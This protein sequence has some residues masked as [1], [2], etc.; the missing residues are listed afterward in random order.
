[1]RN[2]LAGALFALLASAPPAVAELL[3][4]QAIYDLSMSRRGGDM[5]GGSGRI[6]YELR[7]N[8][9]EG[10]TT[11]VRQVTTLAGADG[12]E[13]TLDVTATTFE[14]G[15]A[16]ALDFR[17][18]TRVDGRLVRTVEGRA[19][20]EEDQLRIALRSPQTREIV[21]TPEETLFPAE[22]LR[23]I[24]DAV[25]AGSRIFATP[26]FDGGDAG[27]EVYD[28]L[29][30]IGGEVGEGTPDPAFPEIADDRRWRATISYFDRAPVEGER[31]PVYVVS[32][33]L[34]ENGVTSDMELDFGDF[35]MRGV[36]TSFESFAHTDARADCPPR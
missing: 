20:R 34:H 32:F 31:T 14:T 17:S 30:V 29:A 4:H 8:A 2:V 3:A 18:Q 7:G 1:M 15:E 6:V 36:M 33:A 27:D 24:L 22:H 5:Q 25:R 21:T 16:D 26:I 12:G 23:A 9:C 28:S 10:W 11:N 13:T 19:T 35:A